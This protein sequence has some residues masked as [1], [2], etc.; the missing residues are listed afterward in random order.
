[1]HFDSLRLIEHVA[2]LQ[3]LMVELPVVENNSI[4]NGCIVMLKYFIIIGN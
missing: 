1:M 2:I 3:I 4:N